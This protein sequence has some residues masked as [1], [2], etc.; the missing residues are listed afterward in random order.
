M[1]LRMGWA[2]L[3]LAAA[4]W[5]MSAAWSGAA[6]PVGLGAAAATPLLLLAA[7]ARLRVPAGPAAAAL[8]V[9]VFAGAYLVAGAGGGD[10]VPELRD[11]L[12]RLLT[13]PR[14]APGTPELLLP[15]LLVA[16]L[17]GIWVA[18]RTLPAPRP[19]GGLVAAPAGALAL[20]TV[21]ALLTAGTADP[22]GLMAATLVVLAAAG[23][24]GLGGPRP[25]LPAATRVLA[26][27]AVGILATAL[28]A[29]SVPLTD[30]FEPRLLVDPPRQTVEVPS[31]LPRLAGWYQLGDRPLLRVD[32]DPGV[33]LR[34]VTLADFTG[35]GWSASATY[36]RPGVVASGGL[37]PGHD[38]QTVT[39]SITVELLDGPWLP[40][41]GH[42]LAVSQPGVDVEPATG[43]LILRTGELRPGLR[44]AVTAV[45]DT[46][47]PGE[48]VTAAV[49]AGPGVGR[50]LSLPDPPWL[51]PEYARRVTAGASTPFEQ[52]VA[53]EYA[54]REGRAFDPTAPAGSSYARLETFLFDQ[55][56]SVPGAAAGTSEQ[57]ATAF[58]VL[59]R[60][61]GLP[62][63]VVV[64]FTTRGPVTGGE[65]LVRGVD[66]HA[67][68]EVYFDR[69]GWYAFDPTPGDGPSDD[70]DRRLALDAL[71]RIA[72]NA[73]AAPGRPGTPPPAAPPP[74]VAAPEPFPVVVAAA[75][76]LTVVLGVLLAGVGAVLAGRWAR[77]RRHRRA[78]ARGAWSEVLD[79]LVLLG[80]PAPRGR[81]A[82]ELAGELAGLVPVPGSPQHPAL[83]LAAA[84]DRAAFAPAGGAGTPG[85]PG[86]LWLAL[87][88]LRRA[89]LA[90][91]PLRRRLAW[92]F[93][94][95]PLWRRR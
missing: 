73:A 66:A 30:R 8:V 51:F 24:F 57:F 90:A 3:L 9:L 4:A 27:V 83:V 62:T 47:R 39:A 87:R 74:A 68:P 69:L 20:Y 37:P 17:I 25:P 86:E 14:P 21:G 88:Q 76:V 42:A 35:T 2:G 71:D 33:R 55:P 19:G 34:L 84:A 29:G 36:R 85:G 82:P 49:P 45:L 56:G 16:S 52:A 67:W 80:R 46:P 11:S 1:M 92:P 18:L 93:D 10:P 43:S 22:G 75:T 78:G 50:Y 70:P 60:A 44:Y 59:A 38:Q 53:I 63:R 54:V 94:P 64:G 12:P 72:E 65:R 79:L 26:P 95:R 15:G 48:V 91:A 31:P 5:P 41:P 6:V 23:W 7:A 40:S 77:W 61:V 13:T 32:T 81:P 28:L 58:A 89:V